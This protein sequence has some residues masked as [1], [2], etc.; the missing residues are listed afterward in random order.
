MSH[1]RGF[2][3]VELLVV[4]AI[5]AVLIGLL[6]PAVQKIREAAAR[7]Q[8]SNNLKQLGLALHN[9]ITAYGALPPGMICD[10][11]S[12]TDAQASGFTYLLP[13]LE[14]DNT[15]QLYHFDSPWYA[16]SNYNAVGIPVRLHYCP[17]NRDSG[18]INLAPIAQQWSTPLPPF[19]SAIDYALCKGANGSLIPNGQ[20]VPMSVRGAFDLR[21]SDV[22]HSGVRIEDI[23]DGTST[24]FA[25]GEAAGGTT[26]LFV[27]SLSNPTQPA[28]DP[29]TGLPAII[30]QSWGAASVGDPGHPWYGSVFGVTAQF[31]MAPDPRD[32]PM[33]Q[34]LLTPTLTGGDPRGDNS[35]GKDLVSGFRSRHPNGCNFLF[36][37]G[38]V[39][40]VPQTIAPDLYR[41]LSTINGGE[42]ANTDF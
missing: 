36:C 31:G 14:Q 35:S 27:R 23:L 26:G 7:A 13:F 12:A 25:I 9:H 37:D 21:S 15:Y 2:T 4:I 40:F 20:K 28:T 32:E 17:S 18:Q 29:D 30:D 22:A 8:C 16:A 10:A 11:S 42:T 1:R 6:L 19:A 34:R 41:A 5:I 38:S 24:T 39:R 33:N 3:L